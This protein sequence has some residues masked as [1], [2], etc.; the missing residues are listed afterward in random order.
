[1]FKKRMETRFINWWK[2]GP[3]KHY[4]ESHARAF[5]NCG[6]RKLNGLDKELIPGLRSSNAP[7]FT[8]AVNGVQLYLI[9]SLDK[10]ASQMK[11]MTF[12]II[13]L[14]VT[15]AVIALLDFFSFDWIRIK[16][17]LP[18]MEI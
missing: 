18:W 16:D 14:T 7:T 2:E 6:F 3:F 9:K 8:R 12:W 11:W 10:S 15:L 17:W 13:M 4:P 5:Y 1:M